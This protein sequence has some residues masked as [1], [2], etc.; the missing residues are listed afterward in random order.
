L[1]F[2]AKTTGNSFLSVINFNENNKSNFTS[3]ILI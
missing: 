2:S 1:F 3:F